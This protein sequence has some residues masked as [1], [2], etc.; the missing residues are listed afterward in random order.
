LRSIAASEGLTIK[1]GELG[2][3]KMVLKVVGVALVL[4][5]KRWPHLHPFAI[6][7]MWGVVVFALASA[8]DYFRKFWKAIDI[9]VKQRRRH[10]LIVMERQKRKLERAERLKKLSEARKAAPPIRRP[11]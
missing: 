9:N 11:V 4:M 1:A 10:E 6:T 8:F 5:S 3:T 2:K 7:A